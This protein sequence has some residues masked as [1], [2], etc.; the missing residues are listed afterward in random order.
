MAH[1]AEQIKVEAPETRA[2]RRAKP[3]SRRWS[4]AEEE[5]L[6]RLFDEFGT[7]FGLISLF[8]QRTPKQIKRKFK[9]RASKLEGF[10][11]SES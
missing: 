8:L 10:I 11:P 9:Q 6:D 7:D 3:H 5:H 2:Q 1:L 4:R